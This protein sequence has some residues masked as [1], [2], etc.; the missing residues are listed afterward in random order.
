MQCIKRRR[1]TVAAIAGLLATWIC[2]P[3]L[4]WISKSSGQGKNRN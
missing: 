3:N 4:I 1:Q 2:S